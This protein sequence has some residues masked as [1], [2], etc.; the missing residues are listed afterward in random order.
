MAPIAAMNDL[1]IVSAD[2]LCT[3]GIVL[4]HPAPAARNAACGHGAAARE[5]QLVSRNVTL[6]AYV[7]G[8]QQHAEV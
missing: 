5:Y 3:V 6:S 8:V 4:D 2:A 7:T 1:T